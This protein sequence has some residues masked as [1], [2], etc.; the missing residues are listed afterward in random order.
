[1]LGV[2][3]GNRGD[4]AIRTGDAPQAA[5]CSECVCG[6]EPS[7]RRCTIGAC[8]V[9]PARAPARGAYTRMAGH[10]P[11]RVLR[12]Q[13]AFPACRY[14]LEVR[15][16][17]GHDRETEMRVVLLLA[18]LV[19]CACRDNEPPR[20]TD[21]SDAAQ[22]RAY[23]RRDSQVIDSLSRLA[24]T[25]SLYR[26]NRRLLTTPRPDSLVQAILC[27]RARIFDKHGSRPS[28]IAIQRMID[29]A[30]NGVERSR[31]EDVERQLASGI[32]FEVSERTCGQ[33]PILAPDS[34]NGIS[35]TDAPSLQRWRRSKRPGA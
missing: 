11:T 1:M 17:A 3:V 29:T 7:N 12:H 18:S 21:T 35:L 9:R 2:I 15:A 5:G 28:E 33:L 26:L 20:P 8:F 19:V 31:I 22:Y 25:D 27:E 4:F 34:I 6:E 10:P 16:K 32:A 30:W 23:M 13:L 24:S 14:R